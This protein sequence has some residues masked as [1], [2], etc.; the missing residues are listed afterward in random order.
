MKVIFTWKEIIIL[1][2]IIEIAR[3]PATCKVRNEINGQRKAN[4]VIYTVNKRPKPYYPRTFSSGIHTIT[5]IEW[6][7][8]GTKRYKEFGPVIIKTDAIREIFTWDLDREG[9]YWK[10]TGNTQI[11]TGYYMHHTHKYLTTYG[12]IRGGDTESEMIHIAR[13]IEPVLNHDDDVM[14]EV[15]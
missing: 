12:C 13:I 6:V 4:E 3:Y 9:N 1:N 2:S 5:E 15:L 14:L 11:D 10:P 8:P 7:K